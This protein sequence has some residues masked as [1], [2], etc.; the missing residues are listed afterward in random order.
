AVLP[1]AWLPGRWPVL[2]E[3]APMIDIRPCTVAD[4]EAAGALG[5]LLGSYAAESSMPELGPVS[6]QFEAYRAMEAAGAVHVIGAFGPGLVGVATLL[7]Y[8][9]PHYGGRRVCSM[10]SFFVLPAARRG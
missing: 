8:G 10:E 7:V 4:V 9:L 6:A 5:E 2:R 1:R 3:G